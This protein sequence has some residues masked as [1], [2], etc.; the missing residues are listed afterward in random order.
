MQLDLKT[1]VNV[2]VSLS[3][4]SAARK[5]FNVALILGPSTVISTA[6]RVRTYTSVSAMLQDGF[7]SDSAEY[8]AAQLYFSASSSPTK[9]AVGVKGESETFLAAAEACRA[10]NGEWYV[11]IPLD[12]E[13]ADILELAAWAESASPDTLLAYTTDDESNLSDI[14]TGEAGEQTD[15]IF[16]RLKAKSYRRSFGQ[17]SQTQYAVAATMGYAMGQNRSSSNSAFTL[18]YKKLVG[19]T[20]DD[21]TETQVQYVCGDSETSGVNGNVYVTRAD[22]YDIL[23]EGCMADGTYFDEILNLDMLKNEITLSV[24]DL[25]TSQPKIPNTDSGVA[26]I[27]NVINVACEKFVKTGFIASGEWNGGEVYS[28][29]NGTTLDAGYLVMAEPVADQ[30]QADR[31]ARKAPPIYVCIKTAGAIHYVTIAVTVNR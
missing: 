12:A 26:T 2:Q 11:L 3:A 31:D 23:Q 6:E 16:K 30:S 7:T 10:K 29:E 15:A 27:V 1:I 18:A 24:M 19:V 21:L 5:G 25:L 20:T 14:A 22:S 28:L 8:K 4:R 13:N 9:L 17:Y